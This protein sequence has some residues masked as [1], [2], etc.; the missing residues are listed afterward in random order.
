MLALADAAS[1]DAPQSPAVAS[2]L[3]ARKRKLAADSLGRSTSSTQAQPGA[4][5]AGA[6]VANSAASP[7]AASNRGRPKGHKPARY[8]DEGPDDV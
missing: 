6:V 3:K 7:L 4:E 5:G 1:G 2:R 8:S